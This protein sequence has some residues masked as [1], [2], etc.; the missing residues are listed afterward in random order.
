MKIEKILQRYSEGTFTRRE[1]VAAL[2]R[3]VT[4]ETLPT[5]PRDL[6]QDLR[7]WA[8]SVL[9]KNCVVVGGEIS[10]EVEARLSEEYQK[11]AELIGRD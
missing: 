4:K 3:V 11:A 6:A 5:L 8:E 2:A 10:G 7:E 1:C 9:G